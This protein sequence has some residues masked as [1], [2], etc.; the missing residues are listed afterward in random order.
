MEAMFWR[1]LHVLPIF[2]PPRIHRENM[3]AMIIV[4]VLSAFFVIGSIIFVAVYIPISFE[5]CSKTITTTDIYNDNN[6][7]CSNSV[8]SPL[9]SSLIIQNTSFANQF[10]SFENDFFYGYINSTNS[11]QTWLI[12]MPILNFF[13]S[14]VLPAT[15]QGVPNITFDVFNFSTFE[16][17]FSNLTV[18]KTVGSFPFGILGNIPYNRSQSCIEYIRANL[19]SNF[20]PIVS[21]SIENNWVFSHYCDLKFCETTGCS[22]LQAL[23]IIFL[24]A[25]FLNLF[26]MFLKV[27]NFLIFRFFY[28]NERVAKI[29]VSSMPM[30]E[31]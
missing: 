9:I 3:S 17:L 11:N 18:M 21:I 1:L 15:F 2:H 26:Y 24:S 31:V 6:C 22:D 29:K 14:N 4:W 28:E 30:T 25:S 27:V 10:N 12:I 19:V 20:D 8:A 16:P 23:N 5:Q 13:Y 7:Q